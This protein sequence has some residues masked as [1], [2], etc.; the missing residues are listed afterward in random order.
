[1][2]SWAQQHIF[3][4]GLYFQ[5][6][7]R[8][9]ISPWPFC[10]TSNRRWPWEW[11][12]GA[13]ATERIASVPGSCC[14]H[15]TGFLW[16]ETKESFIGKSHLKIRLCRSDSSGWNDKPGCLV[17]VIFTVCFLTLQ[18]CRYIWKTTG[19]NAFMLHRFIQFRVTFVWFQCLKINV[20]SNYW[21]L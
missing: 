15:C 19:G 1:M 17:K 12:W 16:K 3:T 21:N 4:V 8:W 13:G 5:L 18:N 11:S 2:N 20:S 10:S 6:A 14:A 7:T 9:N